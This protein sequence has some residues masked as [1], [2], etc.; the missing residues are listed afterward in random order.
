MQGDP[1]EDILRAIAGAP[2]LMQGVGNA[3]QPAADNTLQMLQMLYQ[4]LFGQQQQQQQGPLVNDPISGGPMSMSPLR[5]K[6]VG[7]SADPSMGMGY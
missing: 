5:N 3:A 4:K 7:K 1:N 2:Q 6:L